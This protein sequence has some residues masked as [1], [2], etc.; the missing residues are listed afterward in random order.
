[1]NY[2]LRFFFLIS[3]YGNQKIAIFPNLNFQLP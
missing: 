3:Y 2:E 1:M